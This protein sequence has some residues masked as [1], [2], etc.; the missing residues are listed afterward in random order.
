MVE[1]GAPPQKVRARTG[2]QARR[3][4]RRVGVMG[5]GSRRLDA[6]VGWKIPLPSVVQSEYIM[7]SMV[8]RGK[9]GRWSPHFVRQISVEACV[10]PRTVLR[11]LAGGDGRRSMK[12]IVADRVAAAVTKLTDK[13]TSKV[14]T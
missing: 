11:W 2:E 3:T 8:R 5:G 4:K 12:T 6:Q 10:D 14:K 1:K 7:L 13:A 9:S